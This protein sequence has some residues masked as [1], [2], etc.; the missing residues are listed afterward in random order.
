MSDPKLQSLV[1]DIQSAMQVLSD[2]SAA[3]DQ[4]QSTAQAAVATAA[5]TLQDKNTA[6]D[7]VDS[8]IDLLVEYV[9]TLK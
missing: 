8:K 9:N 2:K 4:A 5:G 3:N 7:D 1:D 6:H